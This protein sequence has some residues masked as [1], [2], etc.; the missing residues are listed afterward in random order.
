MTLIGPTGLT[1]AFM[2]ALYG[3]TSSLSLPFLPIYSWCGIWTSCFMSL[4]AITGASSLIELATQFTDDVFNALLAVNFIYEASRSLI[5]NFQNVSNKSGAFLALNIALITYS[6]TGTSSQAKQTKYFNKDVRELLSNS[7]PVAVIFLMS[8]LIRLPAILNI[9]VEFLTVPNQIMSGR[10]LF[11]PIFSVSHRIKL[12]SA[13]PALLLTSLF[14]LDQ[15]ITTRVVNNPKNGMVKPPAYHQ[16]LLVLGLITGIL[17][18]FGLPWQCA[19]TV[20]SLNHVR[21]M[22]MIE[23]KQE[24]D[25]SNV[26][27]IESVC[28][29][30]LSGFT[31]HA[32][33]LASIASLSIL[34]FIPMPVVS[35]IFLFL[36]RKVM[37]GNDFLGRIKELCMDQTLLKPTSTI[38]QVGYKT[39]FSYTLVQALMLALLWTLKSFQKTALFFP[40]VIGLLVLMRLFLLPKIFSQEALDAL[41]TPVA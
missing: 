21:V 39:A 26:E 14:F 15:N 35:G 23:S 25:G 7:G 33:V 11:S 41:D 31:I 16:D 30:R 20:Q 5:Q 38:K 19:A 1:L 18:I 29:N 32:M 34:K 37:T 27:V 28:E 2:S 9:G 10:S 40:S 36:G 22:S 8:L 13:I 24:S 17:S 12:I 3:L 6:L 4:L